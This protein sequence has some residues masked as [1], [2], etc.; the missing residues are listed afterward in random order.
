MKAFNEKSVLAF[1]NTLLNSIIPDG[2]PTWI[3]ESVH[4]GVGYDRLH[5]SQ[6]ITKVLGQD[7][8]RIGWYDLANTESL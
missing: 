1:P 7:R 6:F 5:A 2:L 3:C 8:R 4:C